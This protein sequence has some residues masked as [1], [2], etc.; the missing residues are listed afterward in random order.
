MKLRVYL[1]TSV[2]SAHDDERAPDRLAET[3]EFWSRLSEFDASTSDLAA[4]ELHQTPDPVKRARLEAMLRNVGIHPVT[5]EMLALAERYV[6]DEINIL[7]GLP[8]VE[9]VAPPEM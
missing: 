3:R 2:F 6:D 4:A 8:T 7:S 1:D 9:I 5:D